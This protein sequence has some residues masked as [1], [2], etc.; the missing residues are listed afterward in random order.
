MVDTIN[1]INMVD[2]VNHIY[3]LPLKLVFLPCEDVIITG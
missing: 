2:V 1:Y 3:S